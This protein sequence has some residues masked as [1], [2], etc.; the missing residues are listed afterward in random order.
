MVE[1]TG[2]SAADH[3]T[4]ARDR[5]IEYDDMGDG[6]AAVASLISDLLVEVAE[7]IDAAAPLAEA[8]DIEAHEV[9]NVS[10]PT[11]AVARAILREEAS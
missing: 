8:L 10:G 6:G 11:I 2:T 3:F 9:L 4:W 7:H 5:A 1:Q